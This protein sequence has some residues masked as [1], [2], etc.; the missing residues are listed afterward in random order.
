ME[1]VQHE[2]SATLKG[3]NRKRGQQETSVHWK[4]QNME[5]V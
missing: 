3:G 1:R 5:R 2:E 4:K